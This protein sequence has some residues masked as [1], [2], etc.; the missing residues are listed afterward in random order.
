MRVNLQKIGAP[1]HCIWQGGVG[2]VRE[3]EVAPFCRVATGV[4]VSN[5]KI[6]EKKHANFD[7][8]T[9]TPLQKISVV[10]FCLEMT[11]CVV[12]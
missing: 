5:L 11:K 3:G 4:R 2:R 7:L 12:F 6:Y 9:E 1:G 10:F 8:G